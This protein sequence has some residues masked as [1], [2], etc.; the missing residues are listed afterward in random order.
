MEKK[1]KTQKKQNKFF[2]L[3]M[4]TL[5]FFQAVLSGGDGGLSF[6]STDN[7]T[8]Q[9]LIRS[10]PSA[11]PETPERCFADFS[12]VCRIRTELTLL[13][14]HHA[15][16]VK[17]LRFAFLYPEMLPKVPALC[18]QEFCSGNVVRVR[19]SAYLVGCCCSFLFLVLLSRLVLALGKL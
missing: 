15:A 18:F 2:S 17:L 19:A 11:L 6:C 1:N 4:A 13:H 9:Q 5:E 16:L 3:Y 10:V 14:H 7:K 8:S 12:S